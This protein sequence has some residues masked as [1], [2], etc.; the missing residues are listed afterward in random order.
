MAAGGDDDGGVEKIFHPKPKIGFLA[1]AEA[2]NRQQPALAA[3]VRSAE[4]AADAAGVE[5]ANQALRVNRT[6]HFNQLLDAAVAGIL[7]A[8]VGMIVLLSVREWLMLLAGK[9]LAR[10]KESEPVWLPAYAQVEARRL[11]FLGLFALGLALIKE[12][13]GEAEM[14][15]IQQTS[16]CCESS[17]EHSS[18]VSRD[19]RNDSE[20]AEQRTRR[21]YLAMTENR[22]DGI[23]RCC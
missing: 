2:L 9:Q 8:L 21:A 13:S 4:S 23:R 16:L 20:S 14:Q 18:A 1:K 19:E 6:E 3:A 7:L 22:F 17:H 15:R 11:Q 12:L 10:V 5:R